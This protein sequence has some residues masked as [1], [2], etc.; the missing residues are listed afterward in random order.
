MDQLFCWSSKKQSIVAQSIAEAEYVVVATTIN[1]TIWLR[2][3]MA[4]MNL[5]QREATEI[6]SD[7]Q[8][9]VAIA[10]NPV[11]HG[12]TKYFKIK[13]HFVREVEQ[14]QEI[15][16]VHCNFED[17]LADILTKPLGVSRF[18]NLRARLGVCSMEAKE[19]C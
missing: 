18:E 11:F 16:L 2:K 12:K 19:E 8:S 10:K 7:N 3:L 5:H 13:F 6:R 9:A 14:A 17:Q 15:K 4:D 1:Q